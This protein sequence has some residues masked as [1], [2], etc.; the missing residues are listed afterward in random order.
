MS[1][2]LKRLAAGVLSTPP[3]W[4]I[5]RRRALQ[6]DS[7]TILCYHTLGPD[8]GG[9][10]SWTVLRLADFRQQVTTLKAHYDIVSLDEALDMP[11]A[12]AGRPRA[13][14]TFDDGEAGMHKYLLPF[15]EREKLPVT[16][17]VATGQI[18]SGKP[19]WFDRV[20][21]ACQTN[22]A[23]TLDLTDEGLGHWPLPGDDGAGRW[24][25]L[26]TLLEAMKDLEPARREAMTQRIEAALPAPAPERC[27]APMTRAE[28]AEL[29]ANPLVTIGAHSDCHNLLD[30]IPNAEA[31]ASIQRSR[32][33]LQEWTGQDVAHF[34]YPN[35][36]HNE[37]LHR[38]VADAGF[39]SATILGMTLAHGTDNR[40]ALPRVAIGRYDSLPR[41][42]LRLAM[43]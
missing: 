31:S 11:R 30:Q 40:F 17:Y 32:T 24:Q 12:S 23:Q 42:R 41:F 14:L 6:G 33:L 28:L 5:L 26:G 15:V 27:L 8:R 2:S 25:V 3:L 21:N 43:M 38:A 7:V 37:A 34:A 39:T 18:A 36:N 35:G 22:Q 20:M 4:T 13:V 9:P 29:A 19:F 1:F 16:V 10:D